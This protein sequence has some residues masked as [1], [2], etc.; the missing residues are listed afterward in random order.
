[1]SLLTRLFL[2]HPQSLG[3]SYPEHAAMAARFGWTMV[4]GGAA[5]L[6][7]AVVP[8]WFSHT[9]SDRVKALYGQMKARQP[10]FSATP[11]AFKDPAWQLEYEI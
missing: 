11:P 1:M 10:A 3:E 7:H 6:V 9:A 8:A 5:C 4:V 2:S